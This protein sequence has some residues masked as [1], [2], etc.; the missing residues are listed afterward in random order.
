MS[1][2]VVVLPSFQFGSAPG[3]LTS[4]SLLAG[5]LSSLTA[6]APS[7][8]LTAVLQAAPAKAA[9]PITTVT[10]APAL[11]ISALKAA[12]KPDSPKPNEAAENGREREAA[13]FDGL[14]EK[15]KSDAIEGGLESAVAPLA[16]PSAGVTDAPK[17][18][19]A[20][21]GK[22]PSFKALTRTHFLGVFNDTALKTLFMVW[23]TGA[24]GG[25]AANL[26]I[27]VVTSAFMLPYVAFSS[28]AGPLSD[29][30]ENAKLIRV[31]KIADLVVG[32][33]V[34]EEQEREGLDINS[35]GESAYD[36]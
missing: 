31:L 16:E 3:A 12:A 18:P 25:D 10:P 4:S 9:A 7:P 17:E 29:R 1:A 20:P 23:V 11:A 13:K 2:P 22:R 21:F 32:L 27:G 26:W 5:S 6:P 15:P 34:S 8:A 28:F 33:R 35:H 19:P 14:A 36:Y 24:I 30:L